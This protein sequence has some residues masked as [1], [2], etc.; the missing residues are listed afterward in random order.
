MQQRRQLAIVATNIGKR[1]LMRSRRRRKSGQG[2]GIHL[3]GRHG[4]D[5]YMWALRHVDVLVERGE[6]LGVIGRNG[7]GK[8]TLLR[9][10]AGV[11]A[12]TAGHA[13]VRGRIGALLGVG[14]GFHPQLTGRDNVLLS[15]AIMGLDKHEV[16]A[17]F[18]EIV[19]FSGVGDYLD[20]PVKRYSNGMAARLAFSVA[21]FLQ[22]DVM[23]VDEVLAV[24]DASFNAKA[25]EQMLRMLKD[26][27]SVVYVAHGMQTIRKLCR[28]VLVLDK[29]RAVF[30]GDAEEATSFYEQA[31]VR[32]S[33]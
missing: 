8:T 23:L 27:R 5:E 33:V 32:S 16:E 24:G 31:Y 7:S 28:H 26:G 17:R 19:E 22:A 10:L 2:A 9:I 30:Y 1:Y 18:D 13:E 25:Q 14:T 3:P 20:E 4:P 6:I 29:G 11:T 21:T 15:G 12:P